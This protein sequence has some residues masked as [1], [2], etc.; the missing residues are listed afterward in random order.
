[1]LFKTANKITENVQIANKR[2]GAKAAYMYT[3]RELAEALIAYHEELIRITTD[4]A[5][6]LTRTKRQLTASLA[7]EARWKKKMKGNVKLTAEEQ[8]ALTE[9]EAEEAAA[10]DKE[11]A[12]E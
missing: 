3:P 9:I 7:R 4:N 12:D 11:N 1:M 5:I 8:A 10:A 6:E 2:W